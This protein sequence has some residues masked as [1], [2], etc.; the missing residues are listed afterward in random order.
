MLG[1]TVPETS[2]DE[3]RET[4]SNEHYIDTNR[5]ATDYGDRIVDAKAQPRAVERRSQCTF[6]H[7]VRAPVACH[8]STPQRGDIRPSGT[9]ATRVILLHRRSIWSGTVMLREAEHL[10]RGRRGHGGSPRGPRRGG[11]D[12]VTGRPHPTCRSY[13]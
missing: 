3:H 12:A 6:R 5:P 8:D 4:C 2:I 11:S 1:A 13:S 7:G 9:P 10:A